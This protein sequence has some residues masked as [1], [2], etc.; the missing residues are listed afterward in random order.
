MRPRPSCGCEP[1]GGPVGRFPLQRILYLQGKCHAGLAIDGLAAPELRRT[2][3]ALRNGHRFL[4]VSPG[5]TV[6]AWGAV[7]HR[8]AVSCH[9]R[10]TVVV[11]VIP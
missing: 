4:C 5:S 11:V 1:G 6:V 9:Q 7:K 3:G 2:S 10:L 8:Q